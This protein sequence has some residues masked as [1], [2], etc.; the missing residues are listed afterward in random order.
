M[1]TTM[2]NEIYAGTLT[3]SETNDTV[4]AE[5]LGIT[6]TEYASL[7]DASIDSGT[8]EGHVRTST[9]RRVY[10]PYAA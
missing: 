5:D 7:V 3:D 10:A 1:T 8:A 2:A 4:T 6:E 9:G